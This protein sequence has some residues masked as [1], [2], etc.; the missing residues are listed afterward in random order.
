MQ[1]IT[2]LAAAKPGKRTLGIAAPTRQKCGMAVA[3]LPLAGVDIAAIVR[4]PTWFADRYDPGHDAFHFRRLTRA[5]H[6]AATFLTDDYLPAGA[7]VVISRADAVAAAPATAPI[8]FI[9]HSAF[10]CSTVLARAFDAPGAAMGLK[11]PV[12]FNDLVGWKSRGAAAADLA[13]VLSD[14]LTVL[15]RPFGANEAIVVKPSNLANGFAA[16]ML[17]VRPAARA[18]FLHAPLTTYL[19]SIARKGMTGRLWARDL[20]VKQ[21]RDGTQWP[22]MSAEDFIGQSD[23]QVAAIGWLAQH[24][25]FARIATRWPDRVRTLDSATLMA[26]PAAAM[27]ALAALF[28]TPLDVDAVVAGPAFG[29]H[30]KDGRAFDAAARDTEVTTAERFADE[31]DKVVVW[32][33]AVA[34][35]V[36]L[37]LALPAP[38]LG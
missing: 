26:D 2:I 23:L 22:G 29:R 6:R 30:S 31:I 33:A 5:D 32:T 4:D 16:A 35:T 24:A 13:A 38:L 18:L 11:E 17:T 19:G 14:G 21:I 15:A 34:A 20:L 27:T 28:G 37:D 25:M 3:Q 8:H 36:G 9:F 10:C 1:H 12:L 7:P